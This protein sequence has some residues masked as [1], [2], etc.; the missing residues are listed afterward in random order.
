VILFFDTSALVKF[1]HRE[2]G[3][4]AVTSL[5]TDPDN[6]VWVSELAKLEFV[7]ALYRRYRMKGIDKDRFQLIGRTLQGKRLKLIF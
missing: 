3:T 6:S 5:L 4:D 7:G 2:K 1:F